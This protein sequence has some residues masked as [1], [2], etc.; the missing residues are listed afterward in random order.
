MEIHPDLANFLGSYQPPKQSYLFP[1]KNKQNSHITY[2]AVYLYWQDIFSRCGLD[3]RG[4]SCH[5]TRRWFI[6][7]LVEN[8]TDI[9]TVQRITGHKNVRVLLDYVGANK[10]RRQNAIA[11]IKVAA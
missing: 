8:G 2:N 7:Q 10:Q 11:N 9:A 6:T 1:G 4:F 3:H 5:S